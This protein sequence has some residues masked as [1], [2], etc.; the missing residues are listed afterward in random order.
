MSTTAL[1]SALRLIRRSALYD[2]IVT[3]PFA[4]PWTAR[5]LFD[6]LGALHD[7]LGL[8]GPRPA[9]TGAIAMLLANLMGSL[10]VLWSIVRLRAPTLDH[11]VNDTVARG[12]FSLWMAWALVNGASPLIAG[13][14][15]AEIGW[16]AVQARAVRAA[17]YAR[18]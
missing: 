5:W 4:T 14:L 2:L 15:V 1:T 3:A 18:A 9:L 11:G 8:P 13:F 7:A 17:R 6:A 12:L 10:V 16:G